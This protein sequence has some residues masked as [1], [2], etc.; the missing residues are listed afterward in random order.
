MKFL[1]SKAKGLCREYDK[2]GIFR[3]KIV[4]AWKRKIV[5][6]KDYLFIYCSDFI[7]LFNLK[8]FLILLLAALSLPTAVVNTN[9]F[10]LK[11]F[12]QIWPIFVNSFLS[13]IRYFL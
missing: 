2:D 12:V 10:D 1:G 11:I 8:R 13:G 9:L 5:I 3:Y 7:K 4:P 6:I